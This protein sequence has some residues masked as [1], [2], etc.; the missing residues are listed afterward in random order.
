MWT[1]RRRK[2][3]TLTCV[4]RQGWSV[5]DHPHVDDLQEEEEET[6]GVNPA[7]HADSGE[8]SVGSAPK[9]HRHASGWSSD[10][11]CHK[12]TPQLGLQLRL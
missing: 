2:S 6:G 11:C 9:G 3:L 10:T 5:E 7:G 8:R 12:T 4:E 1:G